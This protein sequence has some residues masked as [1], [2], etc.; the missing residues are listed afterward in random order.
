MPTPQRRALQLT[1]CLK[2]VKRAH[3]V[4]FESGNRISQG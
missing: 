2:K 1:N 3:D 4:R